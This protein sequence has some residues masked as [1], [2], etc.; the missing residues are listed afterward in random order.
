MLTNIGVGLETLKE[1][2]AGRVSVA[3]SHELKRAVMDCLDRP[4]EGKERVVTLVCKLKPV[5]SDEGDCD[6][7]KG[8]FAIKAKVPERTSKTYDFGVTN[9]GHLYFQA[10]TAEAASE[11]S[12]AQEE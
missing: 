1:L 11:D 9:K 5:L 12:Q 8:S 10:D 3:F 6:S 2:D 4:G 7:V